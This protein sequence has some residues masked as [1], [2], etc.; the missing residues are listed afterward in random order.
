MKVSCKFVEMHNLSYRSIFY[1]RYLLW[2]LQKNHMNF[3]YE[4]HDSHTKHL[5]T[6]NI[7]FQTFSHVA[8]VFFLF[9]I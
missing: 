9:Y 4:S 7:M 8:H 3:T 2:L 6:S 5:Y 1:Q